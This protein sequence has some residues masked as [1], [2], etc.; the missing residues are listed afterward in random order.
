MPFWDLLNFFFVVTA[1]HGLLD[2]FTDG[3]LGVAFF[4][5]FDNS[6]YF[7]PWQPLVVSPLGMA[8]FSEWGMKTAASELLWVWLPTVLVVGAVEIVRWRARAAK[9]EALRA[10][11]LTKSDSVDDDDKNGG[12][13]T[14]V[15]DD[16][17]AQS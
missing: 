14:D 17:G 15:G 2:A 6:R 3:G 8:F 12:V 11:L 16:C 1:A 13:G 5:P 10:A 7:F 4:A 9:E